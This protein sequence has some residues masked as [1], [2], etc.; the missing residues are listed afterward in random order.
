MKKS[1]GAAH[2]DCVSRGADLVSIHSQ[3]EEEFLA[4]YSK[5]S[6]KWIGLKHNPAEGGECFKDGIQLE[7]NKTKNK[8]SLYSSCRLFMERWHT[9][10]P[11]QLGS[12]GAQ[13][14]RGARGLRRD[15]EQHQWEPLLV[16]RS[17]L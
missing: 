16:E 4:L 17:Q 14:P 10:L 7:T 13:Q 9:S 15:G 8:L 12:R 3:E 1:W 6:S 5:A 2:E 11:H